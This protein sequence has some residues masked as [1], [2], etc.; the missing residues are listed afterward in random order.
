MS[1]C[2]P[3]SNRQ[4]AARKLNVR[5]IRTARVADDDEAAEK[6]KTD[7]QTKKT[8]PASTA[9]RERLIYRLSDRAPDPSDPLNL[10]L[11]STPQNV[12]EDT[13]DSSSSQMLSG[14]LIQT[15]A[16]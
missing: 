13:Q 1:L 8:R 10:L 5:D 9:E 16:L 12:Q 7:W 6:M 4:K 14:T 15:T 3:N 2:P 11:H